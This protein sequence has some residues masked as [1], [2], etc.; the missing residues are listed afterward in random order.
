MFSGLIHH[1]GQVEGLKGARLT[2]KTN[3][4]AKL[5]DSVAVNGICLTVVANKAGR[6]VFDVSKE[7]S[8]K[9]TIAAWK[10]GKKVNIEPS[11]K[12]SD[13]LGGHIVQGHVDGTGR[14]LKVSGE[15]FWFEAPKDILKGIV[16]KG[17]VT[18]DGV[19]LTAAEVRDGE[20]LVAVIPFT[21]KHTTLGTL[22]AGEKV[23]LET[24]VIGK[25]VAA[26]AAKYIKG[27]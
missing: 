2:V 26:Y 22:K 6:L 10:S 14:V 9:T 3:L 25:F 17:S 12:A 8:A 20:F 16:I 4:K 1:Q 23:N 5:G 11:L 18:I 13:S 15:N 7:T 27:K 24:D 21:R 19:S